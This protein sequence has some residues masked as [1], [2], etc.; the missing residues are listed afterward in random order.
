MR[1]SF[2]TQQAALDRAAQIHEWLMQNDADYAESVVDN[3]TARWDAPRLVGA[4]WEIVIKNR[5]LGA[6]TQQERD[7]L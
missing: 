4:R 6:L 5:C 7:S 2:V 3:Q 1:L